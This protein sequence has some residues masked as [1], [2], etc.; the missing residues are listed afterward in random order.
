MILTLHLPS[1]SNLASPL[2]VPSTK[3]ALQFARSI[4]EFQKD[5]GYK[6]NLRIKPHL[7]TL[8]NFLLSNFEL[9]HPPPRTPPKRQTRVAEASIS[10]FYSISR[11]TDNDAFQQG[12]SR[13]ETIT[14][15][16]PSLAPPQS[17]MDPAVEQSIASAVTSAVTAAI[18]AIQ[19]KHKEEILALREIIKKSLLLKDS[20]FSTP[21]PDLDA[22]SKLFPPADLPSKST[23]RW[24]QA[25]LEYFDPHLDRAHGKGEIVSVGK[26]VYYKNVV[27]FVQRLQ[28]L[29]TFRGATLVKANIATSL[30]GST[31]E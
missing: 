5:T 4:A 15:H 9:E 20:A 7:Q 26:D 21:P 17:S 31:L 27:L 22:S 6:K 2:L 10:S 11:L 12:I 23:E 18:D 28:N 30:R 16:F 3:E 19:A 24:N 1:S 13:L 25:D 8:V 14:S 29:V